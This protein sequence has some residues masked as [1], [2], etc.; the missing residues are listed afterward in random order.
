MKYICLILL[1]NGF[2]LVSLSSQTWPPNTQQA[3]SIPCLSS[4]ISFTSQDQIDQFAGLYP[5]CT[6]IDG[7]VLIKESYQGE[8]TSLAGLSQVTQING[9]LRVANNYELTTLYGL[10]NLDFVDGS[11]LIFENDA[12]T[13][14][15]ALHGIDRI[16]GYL[17]IG[18]NEVL[19]SIEGIENIYY[20]ITDLRLFANP[21]LSICAIGKICTYL[22]NGGTHTISA[23]AP[24]CLNTEEVSSAC[25]S[26][27][28]CSK[29]LLRVNIE[30]ISDGTYQAISEL[31]SNGGVPNDGEVHFKAGNCISMR[32]GF[33]VGRNTIFSAEIE[34]CGL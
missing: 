18:K 30:P 5:N 8:I 19:E 7:T 22:S 29:D 24:G 11:I 25:L 14:L 28:L 27:N 12:L 23:N 16:R 34:N 20:G 9:D 3:V 15:V 13:S 32:A 1:L 2:Y 4:G 26:S 10:H 6:E 31:S 33:S 21:L 17:S